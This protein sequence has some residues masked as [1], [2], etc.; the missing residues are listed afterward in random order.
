MKDDKA[1]RTKIMEG[2]HTPLPPVWSYSHSQQKAGPTSKFY[3]LEGF[4]AGWKGLAKNP[5]S[6]VVWHVGGQE[7]QRD[8]LALTPP[9]V[10]QTQLPT[11]EVYQAMSVPVQAAGGLNNPS[12]CP[13]LCVSPALVERGGGEDDWKTCRWLSEII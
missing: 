4:S 13:F 8:C 3:I 2:S 5:K 6:L 7:G 1:D 11:P 12:P 9:A 10:D